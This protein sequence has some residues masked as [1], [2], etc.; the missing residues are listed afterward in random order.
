MSG[1]T[2]DLIER[3]AKRKDALEAARLAALDG[4]YGP[5]QELARIE[6]AE[7]EKAKEVADQADVVVI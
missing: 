4:D 2:A 6:A 5:A 7:A 3:A 1:D